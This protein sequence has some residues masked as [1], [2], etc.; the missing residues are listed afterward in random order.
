LFDI[1]AGLTC[2]SSSVFR[3]INKEY[4][5]HKISAIGSRA[6]G[7]SGEAL[8]PEGVYMIPMEW[9]GKKICKRSKS[10][11]I[12]HNQQSWELMEYIP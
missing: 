5:P 6:Q 11:K 2:M 9:N 8:L 10:S 4:R 3:K 12:W 1:G 7:A